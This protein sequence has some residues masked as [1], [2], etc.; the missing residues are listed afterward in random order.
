[1]RSSC[2]TCC[3]LVSGRTNHDED[4]HET[5]FCSDRNFL[6]LLPMKAGSGHRQTNRQRRR[7]L[8]TSVP[9]H[10]EL[11][12]QPSKQAQPPTD[13]ARIAGSLPP[14]FISLTCKL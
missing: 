3:K 12:K 11:S 8:V 10:W 1:L 4:R 14:L 13:P 2:P 7:D 9:H 6:A 5:E